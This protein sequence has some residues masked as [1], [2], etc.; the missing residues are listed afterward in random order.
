MK[1][2]GNLPVYPREYIRDVTRRYVGGL[3]AA[4]MFYSE[5]DGAQ[6]DNMRRLDACPDEDT[7]SIFEELEWQMTRE[8]AQKWAWGEDQKWAGS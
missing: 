6:Q 8:E 4:G 5:S 7:E 3:Q 2:L 1:K